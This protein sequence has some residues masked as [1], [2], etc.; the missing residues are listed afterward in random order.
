MIGFKQLLP[1]FLTLLICS[2][3]FA[4]V[5]LN[6]DGASQL[7]GGAPF[8]FAVSSCSGVGTLATQSMN[9]RTDRPIVTRDGSEFD[10]LQLFQQTNI[11]YLVGRNGS[12]GGRQNG[13]SVRNQGT[14]TRLSS[15][16]GSGNDQNTFDP[17]MCGSVEATDRETPIN[18]DYCWCPQKPD[19][20]GDGGVPR[21]GGEGG[22]AGDNPDGDGGDPHPSLVPEPGSFSLWTLLGLLLVT[23]TR[24]R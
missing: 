8:N 5:G 10:I 24:R 18:A 13:R 6:Y 2:A 19:T 23:T 12:G 15:F 17:G 7:Q 20:D 21:V 22:G 4:G 11:H 3:A 16:G 14:G 9:G 1:F